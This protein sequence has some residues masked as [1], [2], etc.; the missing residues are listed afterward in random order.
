VDRE[1][2]VERCYRIVLRSLPVG[3]GAVPEVVRLKALLKAA[4]RSYGFR[5]VE[6]V[7]ESNDRS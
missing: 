2:P 3:P 1:K 7:E 4:L 6:V 5:C